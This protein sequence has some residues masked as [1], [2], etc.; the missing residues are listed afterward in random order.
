MILE[1]QD[2][3]NYLRGLLI[4]IGKDNIINEIEK[5]KVLEIGEKLGFEKNFCIDSVNDFLENEYINMEVPVFSSKKIAIDF[6]N[7]AFN[8]SFLDNNYLIE[9]FEWLKKVS[10]KNDIDN[11]WLEKKITEFAA[12]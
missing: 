7:D 4:L 5:K 10:I 2:K 12:T 8:I 11:N 3:G 9:E 1:Y 6:L